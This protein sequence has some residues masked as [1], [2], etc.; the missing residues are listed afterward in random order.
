MHPLAKR[1]ALLVS[2]FSLVIGLFLLGYN[3]QL[4]SR[5]AITIALNL[6]PILLVIAGFMLVAD[7]TKKRV[8][9]GAASVTTEQY[10]ADGRRRLRGAG[11]AD[12][13][14]L[15]QAHRRVGRG[16]AAP[17]HGAAGE[18]VPRPAIKHETVGD[19]SEVSIA[20]SQPLF[21]APPAQEHVAA[22][23]A[24]PGS[25]CGSPSSCTRRTC[26]W[27]C[28]SST[29]NPLTCARSR[30]ARSS[31]S[32]GRSA[33][34]PGRSTPREAASPSSFPPRVS[35][36]CGF[37]TRSAGSTIRRG[38]W[39]R[40]RTARWSHPAHSDARGS[41]EIDV[42]GPLRNLVLDIEETA[43]S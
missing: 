26:A 37:S 32:A 15:R 40:G 12:P 25:R 17:G 29:W 8:F 42:D 34:S 6:W 38:I 16:C 35:P 24:A 10:P 3:L 4:I 21:P 31:S 9:A 11:L 27:T 5:Q 39:K 18:R 43:E 36:G 33:S 23:A 13:V 2:V 1:I 30:A 41:V 19:R 28:A 7:S 14:L 20:M 22:G